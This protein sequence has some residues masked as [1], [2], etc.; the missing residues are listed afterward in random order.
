MVQ[1]CT[2]LGKKVTRMVQ[3]PQKMS[4]VIWYWTHKN[5]RKKSKDQYSFRC[6]NIPCSCGFFTVLCTDNLWECMVFV[7][8][9][10]W[11]STNHQTSTVGYKWVGSVPLKFLIPK[12]RLFSVK[13]KLFNGFF[14]LT[15]AV[16]DCIQLYSIKFW[17]SK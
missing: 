5:W 7:L 17:D 8:V 11:E 15:A 10:L 16:F 12:D 4:K 1:E 13:A 9:N 2:A 3:K 14:K 6:P